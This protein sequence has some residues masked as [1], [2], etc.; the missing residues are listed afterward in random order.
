MQVAEKSEGKKEEE[1]NLVSK[2]IARDNARST[3]HAKMWGGVNGKRARTS[4]TKKKY[5]QSG[6]EGTKG[7]KIRQNGNKEEIEKPKSRRAIFQDYRTQV[8]GIQATQT[9]S[10]GGYEKKKKEE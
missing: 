3:L 5:Q 1:S 8:K 4:N 6:K 2:G 9:S 10:S 7:G